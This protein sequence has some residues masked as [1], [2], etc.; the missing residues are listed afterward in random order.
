MTLNY[1]YGKKGLSALFLTTKILPF[2]LSSA[3]ENAQSFIFTSQVP[4]VNFSLL[5]NFSPS[6]QFQ[7]IGKFSVYWKF[8]KRPLNITPTVAGHQVR[9]PPLSLSLQNSTFYFKLNFQFCSKNLV[10]FKCSLSS[11]LLNLN[12]SF[13]LWPDAQIQIC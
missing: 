8:H 4:Q 3:F 7:S 6:S 5:E 2:P 10:H 13:G 11:F 12:H 9:L 1:A